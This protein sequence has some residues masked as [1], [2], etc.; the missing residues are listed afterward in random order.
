MVDG[1]AASLARTD[2]VAMVAL[3]DCLAIGIDVERLRT[4]DDLRDIVPLMTDTRPD[5]A[6]GVL[7]LWTRKEA[8]AKA[9]GAGLP[10]D[11]RSLAVPDAPVEV[12]SWLRHD[13]W[14]WVG[15]PCEDGC[16]AALVVK[17]LGPDAQGNFDIVERHMGE[18]GVRAWSLLLPI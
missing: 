7:T 5:D 8:L 4:F 11:V 2:D 16:V 17:S 13:G 18:P 10:D 6:W 9:T 15:C 1:L 14:M 12:G 3:G